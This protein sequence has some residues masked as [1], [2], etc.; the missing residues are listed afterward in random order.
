MLIPVDVWHQRVKLPNLCSLCVHEPPCKAFEVNGHHSETAQAEIAFGIGKSYVSSV[1]HRM[2]VPVCQRCWE[3]L[4]YAKRL[5]RWVTLAGGIVAFFILYSG[6]PSDW[7]PDRFRRDDFSWSILSAMF[8]VA[9]AFVTYCAC[10]I[11]QLVVTPR[12]SIARFDAKTRRFVFLDEQ[13]QEAFEVLNHDGYYQ[14]DHKV[15][16]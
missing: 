4:T 6:L 16:Y 7:R 2:R 1:T 15:N 5:T 12:N 9:G 10:R 14:P 3:N 13:F 11:F 8:G